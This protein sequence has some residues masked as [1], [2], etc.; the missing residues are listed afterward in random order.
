MDA[1]EWLFRAKYI[2][3]EIN[4]LRRE[5]KEALEQALSMTQPTDRVKVSSGG[6]ASEARIL[7]YIEYADRINELLDMRLQ[8]KEEILTAISKIENATYRSILTMRYLEFKPWQKIA[9]S[10]NYSRRQVERLHGGALLII[11]KIIDE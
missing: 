3:I 1:K 11:Q 4:S 6:N 8:V 5:R 2:N 10:L 9:D 7:R